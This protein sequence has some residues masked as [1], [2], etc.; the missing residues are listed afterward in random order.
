[1]FLKSSRNLHYHNPQYVHNVPRP[2]RCES[3]TQSRHVWRVKASND[4][5]HNRVRGSCGARSQLTTPRRLALTMVPTTMASASMTGNRIGAPV[6]P[7]KFSK[8]C[9]FSLNSP[10]RKIRRGSGVLRAPNQVEMRKTR[11]AGRRGLWVGASS[12]GEE[13]KTK[14]LESA[15]LIN[16]DSVQVNGGLTVSAFYNLLISVERTMVIHEH[17]G[18]LSLLSSECRSQA[19]VLV[20]MK[21]TS[22]IYRYVEH[23]SDGCQ[24]QWQCVPLAKY[25]NTRA[26]SSR[27]LK[28]RVVVFSRYLSMESSCE[29]HIFTDIC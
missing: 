26:F 7:R 29:Q 24:T 5:L 21:F 8:I 15:T 22:R 28:S 9:T 13:T 2:L 17:R 10:S 3:A 25:V 23:V 1:M 16:N 4:W 6:L 14:E 12:N 18:G 19:M 27:G 20:V 11:S